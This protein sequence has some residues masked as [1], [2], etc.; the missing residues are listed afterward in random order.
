MIRSSPI[1]ILGDIG[2]ETESD[3]ASHVVH[4]SR[5]QPHHQRASEEANTTCIENE[6]FF[7]MALHA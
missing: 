3:A 2:R 6:L 4:S 7:H 5:Q 1:V